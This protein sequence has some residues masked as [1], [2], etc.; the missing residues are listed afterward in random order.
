MGKIE[1]GEN[2]LPILNLFRIADAIGIS[3]A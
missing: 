2:N 1:R 3:A